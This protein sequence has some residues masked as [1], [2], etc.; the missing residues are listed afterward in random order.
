MIPII[1]I[2]NS[3]TFEQIKNGKKTIEIRKMGKF[4]SKL[5]T[6]KIIK[7]TNNNEYIIC[8]I[9]KI[10]KNKSFD[11]II[12][13]VSLN[14]VNRNITNISN[15]IIYYSSYYPNIKTDKL[16]AIFFTS[17]FHIH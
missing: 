5:I 11:E 13:L 8:L 9:K 4:I 6:H 12:N 1:Y 16:C 15:A 3:D 14:D 2:R 7:F 10:I 17:L